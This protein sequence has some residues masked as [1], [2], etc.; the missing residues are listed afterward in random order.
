MTNSTSRTE[1]VS[2]KLRVAIGL[3]VLL[4]ALDLTVISATLPVI[5][6][7]LDLPLP[8]G[9]R[10]AAWLVSAYLIAYAIGIL[11]AGR[12]GDAL[13]ERRTLIAATVI[14]GAASALVAG[15]GEWST[16]LVQEIAYRAFEARPGSDISGLGVLVAGRALQALGAGA[17]VPVGMSYGW[18]ITG[19]A[20]W[21]GFIAAVDM[22]GWTLGHL[23]GGVV[24]SLTD[25]RVAF[26]INLPLTAVALVLLNRVKR[27]SRPT[28]KAFPVVQFL[29]GS[30]GLALLVYGTTG[31]SAEQPIEWGWVLVGIA[32]AGA[33]FWRGSDQLLPLRTAARR[34]AVATANLVLGYL[35]FLTLAFV[36]LYVSVLFDAPAEVDAWTTGWLL[37][38]F[39]LPLV[40]TTWLGSRPLPP[41]ALPLAAL[42]A[43]A[44]F[45]MMRS[46]DPV[47]SAMVPSLIVVGLALGL[48]FTPLAEAVLAGAPADA[49]GG[50]SSLVILTRLVGMAIGTSVL[51]GY[52]LRRVSETTISDAATLLGDV[53]AAFEGAAYLGV[54]GAILL[55]ILVTLDAFG[56][57]RHST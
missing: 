43:T 45:A 30:T 10:Q 20:K 31:E 12:L 5:I 33:A 44:G 6:E 38:A 42:A 55:G 36:P 13:G 4:G 34:P 27:P 54:A 26:W 49:A 21:L 1:G 52:I 57:R 8:G 16:N 19:S 9:T 40:A 47:A 15:S 46:W 23:Y 2:W 32:L 22:A 51:T 17:M 11:G 7:E 24:V 56:S 35:V 28:R 41:A 25:W 18:R 14:F 39:T 53:E 3:P 29:A 37:T 48:F 50:A